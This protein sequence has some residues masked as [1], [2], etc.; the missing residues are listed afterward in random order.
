MTVGS[1]DDR[2]SKALSA[3]LI[4]DPVELAE[5]EARNG[6]LQFDLVDELIK[7][8]SHADRPF[9][10]RPSLLLSLHRIALDGISSYAVIFDQQASTSEAAATNLPAL[11]SSRNSSRTCVTT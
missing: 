8:H 4:T 1:N 2:Q 10:L 9:R 6:L 7:A 11:I 3:E 5:R